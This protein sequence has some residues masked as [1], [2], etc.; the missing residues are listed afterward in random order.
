M[1]SKKYLVLFSAAAVFLFFALL[2][3][4]RK[5]QDPLRP[6]PSSAINLFCVRSE[7]HNIRGVSL[8]P[9]V[10]NGASVTLLKGYY[11]CNSFV[12]GDIV[13]LEF[14]TRKD[15]LVKIIAGMPGD[16]MRFEGNR[17]YL[18]GK[19]LSNSTNVPYMFSERAKNILTNS[20]INEMI[21]GDNYLVLG[22]RAGES[23]SFDSRSF[24][25]IQKRHIVG[26]VIAKF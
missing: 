18:N 22:D 19:I 21:E 7:N 14:S 4:S 3:E 6:A 12:R 8:E 25:F 16:K 26:R 9:I 10:K 11:D 20:L 23:E 2:S 15:A 17:L 13:A 1:F 24:G 5:F